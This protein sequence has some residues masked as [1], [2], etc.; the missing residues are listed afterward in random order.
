[1]RSIYIPKL[2]TIFR[3]LETPPLHFCVKFVV[4]GDFPTPN[5]IPI[6]VT[7]NRPM[8]NLN[9]GVYA[10]HILPVITLTMTRW[11]HCVEC[12]QYSIRLEALGYI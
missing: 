10:V 7:Q 11:L 6:S 5:F 3:F 1:M 2:H 4:D 9:I 12:P 8:P